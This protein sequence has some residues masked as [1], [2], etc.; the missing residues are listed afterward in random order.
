MASPDLATSFNRNQEEEPLSPRLYNPGPP[1]LPP[2]EKAVAFARTP[3]EFKQPPSAS[4]RAPAP[5]PLPLK[6]ATSSK[7]SLPFRSPTFQK[8]YAS[9]PQSAPPTKTTILEK[10]ESQFKRGARTGVP[11]T[12]YSPYTPF[13]VT[14]PITP[15]FLVGKKE[16]KEAMKTLRV[17][18][19]EEDL[20]K[21]DDDIWGI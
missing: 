11:A 9:P 19:E 6:S 3:L 14:T 8:Q 21:N 10:R 7:S 16:R 20:V 17:L 15:G 4:S 2:T 18:N 12:P 1:P 13:S 5:S